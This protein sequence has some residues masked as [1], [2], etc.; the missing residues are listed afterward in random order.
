M[1]RSF[2]RGTRGFFQLI[3]LSAA[4]GALCVYGADAPRDP[5]VDVRSLGAIGD[6]R[7]HR[8][9]EW[10]A[11]GTYASMPAIQRAHPFVDN[12]DWTID[13]VAFEEAK[14]KLPATGGTIYFPA[15]RYVAGRHGWRIWR[16]HV[17]LLGDGSERTILATSPDVAEGLILSPYRHAGWI[18]GASREYPYSA[19]SGARGADNV[20]LI[21]PEWTKD[22]EPGERVFIRNGAN[23]FDQ[24]YGEFNE[25]SAATIQGRL[26]FKHPLSRDYTIAQFNWA[27]EVAE[28][29]TF[30]RQ[31]RAVSVKVRAGEGFFQ[32]SAGTTVTIGENI[33]RVR[34]ASKTT[35]RLENIGRA[36]DPAGTIIA[37]G[38]KIGKARSVIKVTRTS[39]NFRCER[40]QII[41]HRKVVNLS[42]SYNVVFS[43]CILRRDTRNGEFSGGVTIDGDGGRFARFD[44][45]T[46]IA[47]PAAGMQFA[48]SFGGVLFSECR[49]ID[50]NVAFTEFNFDCEVRDSTFEIN[51][52]RQL[53]Q[54]IIAGKSC[55]DLRFL[56][57]VIRASGVKTIFDTYS[58]IHSQKHRGEGDIVVQG[59]SIH[60]QKN[61]RVFT[62][63]RA[64]HVKLEH[65]T[66]SQE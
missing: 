2:T 38:A 58:D 42:N 25:I 17:R 19:H 3:F 33:F 27:A 23:R 49:F 8:I 47:E 10:I 7:I 65:N 61:V 18:E 32:P 45:C 40:L 9:T 60:T 28:S 24:D 39:R 6:G 37:A 30:P 62:F 53:T 21:R 20:Q 48:R 15:G 54:A 55:G 11:A 13:E 12:A 34:A 57:N 64:R 46:L 29:F 36:N 56:N 63:P 44:R 43:D 4:S 50:A 14:L 5:V 59:N 66:V 1:R 22:F 51:G 41:G 52:T 16:D 35:L 26:T 31:G